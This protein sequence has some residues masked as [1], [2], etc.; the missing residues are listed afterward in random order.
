MGRVA[1]QRIV[2]RRPLARRHGQA[3]DGP[4]QPFTR[5][6]RHLLRRRGGIGGKVFLIS[7]GVVRIDGALRQRHRL[8]IEA[9][10][11]LQPG[12][13]PCHLLCRCAQHLVGVRSLGKIVGEQRIEPLSDRCRILTR[14]H[15][16]GDFGKADLFEWLY[17]GLDTDC[18]LFVP[19]QR[20]VKA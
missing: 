7:G 1:R 17:A 19:N 9:P 18:D 10:N 5:S 12:N 20:V 16:D 13:G 6:V 11:L 2:R 3:E 4:S 15:V 8:A 14:L